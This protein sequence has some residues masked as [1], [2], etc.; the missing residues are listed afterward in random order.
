MFLSVLIKNLTKSWFPHFGRQGACHDITKSADSQNQTNDFK[1]RILGNK[2][3][4]EKTQIGWSQMLVASQLSRN[5]FLVIIKNLHRSRFQ[6]FLVLSN[7]AWFFSLV[8]NI[9]SR[10]VGAY[11][12]CKYIVNMSGSVKTG[13][14]SVACNN[15]D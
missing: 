13:I 12:S 14:I 2:K 11:Y 5:K 8:A 10:M 1:L 7:F 4:L 15:G 3:V 6:N 9:L